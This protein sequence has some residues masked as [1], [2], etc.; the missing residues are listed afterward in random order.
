MMD[1]D[2]LINSLRLK[3]GIENVKDAVE[4]LPDGRSYVRIKGM[5]VW[6]ETAYDEMFGPGEYA[7]ALAEED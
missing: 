5:P 3:Y 6:Y 7:K 1:T 2:G 4:T